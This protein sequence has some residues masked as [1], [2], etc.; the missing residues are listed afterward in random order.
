MNKI[1]K[2]I[3]YILTIL[4]FLYFIFCYIDIVC[5]NTTPKKAEILKNHNYN[6][7]VSLLNK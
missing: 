6:I 1:I 2:K 7:I 4:L 5:N 3:I